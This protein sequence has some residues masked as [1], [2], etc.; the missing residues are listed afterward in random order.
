MAI[1]LFLFFNAYSDGY[2]YAIRGSMYLLI[3]PSVRYTFDYIRNAADCN[4][5]D[6]AE[7]PT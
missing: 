7:G 1:I 3:C 4:A 5:E 6:I 2:A